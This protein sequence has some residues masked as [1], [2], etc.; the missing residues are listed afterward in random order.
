VLEQY[1][2]ECYYEEIGLFSECESVARSTAVKHFDGRYGRAIWNTD[3][4]RMI[5]PRITAIIDN[6]LAENPADDILTQIDR[7]VRDN[8][9]AQ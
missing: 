3:R 5:G 6:E 9:S 2:R 4:G 1:A 8:L 7:G